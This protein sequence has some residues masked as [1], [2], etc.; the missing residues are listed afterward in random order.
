MVSVSI[1]ELLL[2]SFGY[3]CPSRDSLRCFCSC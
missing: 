2:Q 3:S 1:T